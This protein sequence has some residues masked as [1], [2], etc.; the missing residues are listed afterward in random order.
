MRRARGGEMVRTC[1]CATRSSSSRALRSARAPSRSRA[2]SPAARSPAARRPGAWSSQRRV[3]AGGVRR[4]RLDAP[5]AEWLRRDPGG[6]RRGVVRRRAQQPGRRVAGPL[7][8]RPGRLRGVPGAR[9]A[10]RAR[11]PR[12]PCRRPPGAHG[13]RARLPEHGPPARG[14]P[15]ARV[16][17][18]GA[19]MHAMPAEPRGRG[20]LRLVRRDGGPSRA[21]ARPRLDAVA[22]HPCDR[23]DRA[24]VLRRPAP[25]GARAAG[26]RRLPR[27]GG[28]RVRPQPRARVPLQRP[29]RPRSVARAG[30]GAL[31]ARP[32][33]RRG[34][35]AGH[36]GA[37]ERRA[38]RHRAGRCACRRWVARGARR[39]AGRPGARAG[40]S[41]RRGSPRR[42]PGPPVR[43][44][45][46]DGRAVTPLVRGGRPV[47]VVVHRA[48]LLDDPGLLED[49]GAAAGLALDHE[50]LQAEARARL[51]QLRASR[52]R[53]VEAGDAERRRLERDLHDGAQQRLVVLSFALRLL[54]AELDGDDAGQSRRRRG[55]AGRRA[56]GAARARAR[57]LPGRARRRGPRHG[58]GGARRGRAGADRD[59]HA[60]RGAL[61]PRR[62]GRRLLPRRRGRQ[63][64]SRAPGSTCARSVRRPP[65]R[66]DRQRRQPRRRPRR[67][68]G[69]DRCA[70]RP[71]R[72][73]AG[74]VG[75]PP[76]E[77]RSRADR[78]RR[79]R[80]AVARGPRAAA[81]RCRLRRRRPGDRRCRS[82]CGRCG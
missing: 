40:L 53:T 45:E 21:R 13:C 34:L 72:R 37:H 17:P 11:L 39:G 22:R 73:R 80:D 57:D 44:P 49:V 9:R 28:G 20:E 19:G 77:R 27:A 62:R 60:A 23:A 31:P 82:C 35:G 79:R 12:R 81:R 76:C 66:R 50:R 29:R 7:H 33:R 47:A 75:P 3:R 18:R 26:G 4:G 8:A 52:A 36:A 74:D 38:A 2:A 67:P 1:G 71:A 25:E 15:R 5:A 70:R 51:E 78:D 43:L 24:L 56:R 64:R 54:R 63:A 55:G 41:A 61:P 42:C 68:G 69:P 46:T 32:R 58:A 30:G 10:R 59:R 16:R 14:A 65:A 6:R 48:E